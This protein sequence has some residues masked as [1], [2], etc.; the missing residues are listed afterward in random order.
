MD[1]PSNRG[2]APAGT[3]TTRSRFRRVA[4]I[5][6]LTLGGLVALLVLAVLYLLLRVEVW[7]GDVPAV[8]STVEG[9]S[10][11]V[12]L[13]A[14]LPPDALK[15]EAAPTWAVSVD[16]AVPGAVAGEAVTCRVRQTFQANTDLATGPQTEVVRCW[17]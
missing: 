3:R 8:V 11:S 16:E 4:V 6:L 1:E 14:P 9:N 12:E 2:G 15:A 7:E 13:A 10:M 17:R 5:V